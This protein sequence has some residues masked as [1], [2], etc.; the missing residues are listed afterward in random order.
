MWPQKSLEFEPVLSM[1]SFRKE[2]TKPRK[3]RRVVPRPQRFLLLGL[4][5]RRNILETHRDHKPQQ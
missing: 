3:K 1:T 5:D 4:Y 2:H